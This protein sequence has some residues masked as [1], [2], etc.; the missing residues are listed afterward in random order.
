MP[1]KSLEGKK[2]ALIVAFRDFRDDEYFVPKKSLEDAGIEILTV[3]TKEG[4]AIGAD[5]GEARVDFLL[6]NLV[7]SDF[8][9]IIFIGGPGALGNLDNEES[10]RV[11]REAIENDKVLAAICISS[12][13]LAKAGVLEGKKATVWSNPL[14]KKPI[15][16]LQENGAIFEDEP[17]V[18]DGKIVT[19]NGPQ[20]AKQF[21]ETLVRVLTEE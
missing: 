20:A 21:G 1:E 3:S 2:A 16:I 12:T 14:N 13:I 18:V 11:A 19:G 10:Y 6:G 17:V 8:D 5:G 15:E 7:V 4:T 9:A